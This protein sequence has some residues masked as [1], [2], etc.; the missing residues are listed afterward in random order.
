MTDKEKYLSLGYKVWYID[1]THEV[2][3]KEEVPMCK[4]VIIKKDGKA[5]TGHPELIDIRIFK[6]IEEH[7]ICSEL[8]RKKRRKK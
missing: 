6:A 4:A 8:E 1:E 7:G 5:F 3:I 2:L